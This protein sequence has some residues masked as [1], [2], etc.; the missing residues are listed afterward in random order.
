VGA[1][2]HVTALLAAAVCACTSAHRPEAAHVADAASS[3]ASSSDAAVAPRDALA[4]FHYQE[5]PFADDPSN[6]FASDAGARKLGQSLFFDRAFSGPLI[7]GDNDGKGGTLGQSGD[8]GRV[9]CAD[10]HV[11]ATAFVDTRSPHGQ[12]S[13]AAQW[14]RRRAPTLLE[15]GGLSLYDWD[16]RRDSIWGQAIGVMESDREFNS[17]RLFVAEQMFRLH[18]AEYEAVFGPMPALDDATRFPALTPDQAGCRE[19]AT[20]SGPTY[21]CRGKPSDGA[22]YDGMAPA[23]QQAAT[24]VMVNAGKAMAAYVALLR[25][26]PGRFDAW[27]DGN[28]A[29]LSPSEQRGAGLFAGKGKCVSCHAGPDF[30]DGAFHD[31]GLSP[32]TVAVAFIDSG[33][34]GAA[35]GVAAALADPMN[36]AGPFSDG[37]RHA[38]PAGVDPAMLGAF[39]TPTLRCIATQPSFMHTGQLR[40]LDEVVAFHDRGGDPAGGYPGTNEL[41]PLGLTAGECADIVAFLVALD[42]AGPPDSLRGPPD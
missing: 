9:S 15:S 38:L 24:V 16:G 36:T 13:L 1:D 18:R 33:D 31:V 27:L 34:N 25:C 4:T 41:S 6:R 19:V 42:G 32:A 5:A 12:I 3:G 20:R 7:E 35:D 26:G 21:P 2:A 22:D 28:D 17:G 23:D 11:P 8:P 39:R 10:C 29:A 40:S 30:T 14:T 37:D